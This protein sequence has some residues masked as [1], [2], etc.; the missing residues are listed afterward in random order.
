MF[1]CT[2]TVSL[3]PC[4]SLHKIRSDNTACFP[5]FMLFRIFLFFHST[6]MYFLS[7]AGPLYNIG[8][9]Y[10]YVFN[11]LVDIMYSSFISFCL[12]L[13]PRVSPFFLRNSPISGSN[14][15]ISEARDL[16]AVSCLSF[17]R[18]FPRL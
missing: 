11:S 14:P 2:V 4:V 18:L 16:R 17:V 3:C 13:L 10:I 1:L 7:L 5:L 12:R 9:I 6:Y 15:H 8:Y